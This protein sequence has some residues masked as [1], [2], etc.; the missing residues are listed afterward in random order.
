MTVSDEIPCVAAGYSLYRARIHNQNR[1]FMARA[2]QTQFSGSVTFFHERV[3]PERATPAG[4][5]AMID[6]YTLKLPPSPAPFRI[7]HLQR[8]AGAPTGAFL[9]PAERRVCKALIPCK[10]RKALESQ[11]A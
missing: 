2:P 10:L 7:N 4:Y 9:L 3:L 11:T 6:A 8:L 1:F 5:A